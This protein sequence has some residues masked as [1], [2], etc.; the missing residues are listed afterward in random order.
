MRIHLDLGQDESVDPRAVAA[1][2]MA[3]GA[4]RNDELLILYAGEP[5]AFMA[6]RLIDVAV[7]GLLA[8]F[9]ANRGISELAY[10]RSCPVI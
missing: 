7:G 8:S 10:H 4:D 5:T 6:G 3:R 2:M 9:L 1:E